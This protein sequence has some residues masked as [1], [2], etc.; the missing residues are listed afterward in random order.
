[1]NSPNRQLVLVTS[2]RWTDLIK[3]GKKNQRGANFAP[4]RFFW[5]IKVC[6]S[7]FIDY[8]DFLDYLDYLDVLENQKPLTNYLT[9]SLR[10]M[11]QFSL[12][13]RTK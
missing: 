6:G 7:D 2:E 10:M 1:M 4:R 5:K 9:T 3:V 13:M 8:L 12:L 11:L